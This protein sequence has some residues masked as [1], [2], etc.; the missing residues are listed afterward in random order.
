MESWVRSTQEA[1]DN[2][3]QDSVPDLSGELFDVNKGLYPNF[4][5]DLNYHVEGGKDLMPPDEKEMIE[6][7]LEME[8]GFFGEGDNRVRLKKFIND[9]IIHL[10]SMGVNVDRELIK[11]LY[12]YGK[13]IYYDRNYWENEAYFKPKLLRGLVPKDEFDPMRKDIR[14]KRRE[15]ATPDMRM[16]RAYR[17]RKMKEAK[18]EKIQ[19]KKIFEDYLRDLGSQDNTYDSF[20]GSKPRNTR[21]RNTRRRNTRR[22]NTR[23]R[24]AIRRNTRRRNTRRRNTRRRNTRRRV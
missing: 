21:R 22:R 14:I 19:G 15:K 13:H 20:G 4:N 9:E 10:K 23:R 7:G 12:D 3:N 16:K 11:K 24:S 8:D 6:G 5:K 18:K 1:L 2:F 17:R